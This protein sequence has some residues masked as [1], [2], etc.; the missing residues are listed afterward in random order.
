M[1]LKPR[2]CRGFFLGN[3]G[4]NSGDSL[5]NSMNRQLQFRSVE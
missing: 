4:G 1:Y 3:S 5:L 2:L